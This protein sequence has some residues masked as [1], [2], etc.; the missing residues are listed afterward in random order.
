MIDYSLPRIKILF[1]LSPG[2]L[3]TFNYIPLPISSTPHISPTYPPPPPL[4]YLL[5]PLIVQT[6]D[7]PSRPTHTHTVPPPT[8]THTHSPP[9]HIHTHMNF[10]KGTSEK[11][12]A[13]NGDGNCLRFWARF[14]IS[15]RNGFYASPLM[16]LLFPFYKGPFEKD[17][18]S[19]IFHSLQGRSTSERIFAKKNMQSVICQSYV[20]HMFYQ[21]TQSTN[22]SI[23]EKRLSTTRFFS[24][25]I[26]NTYGSPLSPR[27]CTMSM[28][29]L[30]FYVQSTHARDIVTDSLSEWEKK[31][32]QFRRFFLKTLQKEEKL[33]KANY[34]Q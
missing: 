19:R 12:F 10:Q 32:N 16:G 25:S 26:S 1:P 34:L 5:N 24:F 9:T 20:R 8:F 2:K 27:I 31:W 18:R 15:K 17:E 28:R 33:A 3:K 30:L 21:L 4:P 11:K 29:A 23:F 7:H 13:I 22:C 6:F 14:Q